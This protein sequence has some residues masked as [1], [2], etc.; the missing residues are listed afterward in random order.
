MNKET[1]LRGIWV[2]M[3]ALYRNMTGEVM[4]TAKSFRKFHIPVDFQSW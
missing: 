2:E 1:K 4:K 3:I